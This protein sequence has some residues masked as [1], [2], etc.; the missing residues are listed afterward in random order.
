M[1]SKKALEDQVQ[2]MDTQYD[3]CNDVM[4]HGEVSGFGPELLILSYDR[5]FFPDFFL[6]ITVQFLSQLLL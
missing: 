1:R 5:M 3:L 4:A 6:L 2:K